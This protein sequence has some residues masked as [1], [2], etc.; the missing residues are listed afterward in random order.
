MINCV[1]SALVNT[2]HDIQKG[3]SEDMVEEVEGVV[4]GGGCLTE[5]TGGRIPFS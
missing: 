4:G 1:C 5:V 2:L 3:I